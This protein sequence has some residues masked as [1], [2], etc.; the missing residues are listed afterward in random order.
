MAEDLRLQIRNSLA[1]AASMRSQIA[2]LSPYDDFSE[3]AGAV[4]ALQVDL[5][6]AEDCAG[7]LRARL[8]TARLNAA[9]AEC[10]FGLD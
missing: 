8:T 2:Q 1:A 5:Q 4:V 3:V 10:Y 7:L 9:A 6:Q